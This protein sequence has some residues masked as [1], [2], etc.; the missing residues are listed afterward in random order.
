MKRAMPHA[1]GI[2]L[3]GSQSKMLVAMAGFEPAAFRV[4][5]GRSYLLRYTAMP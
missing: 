4:S 1:N 5:D 2:W 3:Y